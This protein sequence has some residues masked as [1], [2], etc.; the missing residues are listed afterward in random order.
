M[1]VDRMLMPMLIEGIFEEVL[2]MLVLPMCVC[3]PK[4]VK[5]TH[6]LCMP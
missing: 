2:P 1:N 6:L 5:L 3:P 4:G